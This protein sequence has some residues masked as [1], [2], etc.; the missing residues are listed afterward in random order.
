MLP[1]RHLKGLS[2]ISFVWRRVERVWQAAGEMPRGKQALTFRPYV[3]KSTPRL[4][5][6]SLVV[7]DGEESPGKEKKSR[8]ES[9]LSRLDSLRHRLYDCSRIR[10]NIRAR[11]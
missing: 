11:V 2:R 4:I 7:A 6:D 5:H 3:R 1:A 8:D 10:H 9:R